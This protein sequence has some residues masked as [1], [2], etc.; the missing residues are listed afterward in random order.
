M[1]PADVTVCSAADISSSPSRWAKKLDGEVTRIQFSH[2]G[3]L[4]AV[5]VKQGLASVLEPESALPSLR[6]EVHLWAVSA[7]PAGRSDRSLDSSSLGSRASG[8]QPGGSENGSENGSEASEALFTIST[9]PPSMVLKHED[10]FQS[11]SFRQGPTGREAFSTL[12]RCLGVGWKYLLPSSV[13][14]EG[15]ACDHL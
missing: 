11:A 4:A 5:T 7:W 2:D 9:Q 15:L 14:F 12:L 6:T 3:R 8:T 10:G 1:H 13:D